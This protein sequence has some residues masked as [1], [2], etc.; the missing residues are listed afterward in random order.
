M[1]A[2]V[3]ED[4]K[5][6]LKVIE[7]AMAEEGIEATLVNN[8]QKA[9]DLLAQHEYD[10]IIT[11]IHMPYANGDAV[12]NFVHNEQGKKTPVIMISSDSEEEVVSMAL[13]SGVRSFVSKPVDV[14]RLRKV[15]REVKG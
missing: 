2:L 7:V 11:D 3:C 10:L 15:I 1:K 4:D 8:G 5:V 6:V 12:L 13:K 14:E 9:L